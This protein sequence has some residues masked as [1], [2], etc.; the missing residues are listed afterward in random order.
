MNIGFCRR[1][2]CNMNKGGICELDCEYRIP[3]DGLRT[4]CSER[5]PTEQ[6]EQEELIRWCDETIGKDLMIHIPNER[7]CS[8]VMGAALK[9]QGVRS[10]VPDNFLTIPTKEYHGLFIELKRAKKSLSRVTSEQREWIKNL[11]ERG[12]KAVICYG[13]EEA[14]K[15]VLRY[16]KK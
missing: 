15:A 13:A 16:L 4:K 12:Y 3:H 6:E 5:T 14:K 8:A 2:G 9:R 11:N 10:G 1:S 7:K